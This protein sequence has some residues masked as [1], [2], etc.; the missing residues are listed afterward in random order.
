MDN[1]CG[2]PNNANCGNNGGG[3]ITL[4]N[5]T[6]RGAGLIFVNGN[7][8]I[9]SGSN[10]DM[11]FLTIVAGGDPGN[12]SYGNITIKGS[13]TYPSTDIQFSSGDLHNRIL[14]MRWGSSRRTS[15]R[16][17]GASGR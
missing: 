15:F 14:P 12:K 17:H 2:N 1:A 16:S 3:T 5:L 11:G 8:T 9:N 10:S 4:S 6:N 7:V 13:I